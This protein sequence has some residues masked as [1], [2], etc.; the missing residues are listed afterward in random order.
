MLLDMRASDRINAEFFNPERI[1][2]IADARVPER[3]LEDAA[4]F[5]LFWLLC[6]AA[7]RSSWW[8]PVAASARRA[9]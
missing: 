3:R 4:N 8:C 7:T 1:L 6:Q 2:A 5:G 9:R